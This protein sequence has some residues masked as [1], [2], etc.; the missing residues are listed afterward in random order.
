[1]HVYMAAIYGAEYSKNEK[2]YVE[3]SF[4]Q[5]YRRPKELF[6]FNKLEN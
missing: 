2:K 4:I 6:N 3:I 5:Y 1:M